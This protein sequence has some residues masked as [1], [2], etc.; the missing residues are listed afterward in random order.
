MQPT[1]LQLPRLEGEKGMR[2]QNIYLPL[3]LLS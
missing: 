2:D 1:S 3:S